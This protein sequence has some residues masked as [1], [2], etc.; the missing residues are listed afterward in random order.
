MGDMRRKHLKSGELKRGNPSYAT[1][2]SEL[3]HHIL[4]VT[5]R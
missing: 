4:D 3:Y 5:V 2:R 1:N